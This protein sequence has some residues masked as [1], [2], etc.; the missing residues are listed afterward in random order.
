MLF[1]HHL[2]DASVLILCTGL[3]REAKSGEGGEG[4]CL[5]RCAGAG[6]SA[7]DLEAGGAGRDGLEG[8]LGCVGKGHRDGEDYPQ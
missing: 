3:G 7:S 2:K 6:L 5:L 4:I 8:Q 1:S